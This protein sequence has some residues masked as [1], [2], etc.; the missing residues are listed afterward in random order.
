MYNYIQNISTYV[1]YSSFFS[2][3]KLLFDTRKIIIIMRKRKK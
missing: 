1:I 3:L 2:F